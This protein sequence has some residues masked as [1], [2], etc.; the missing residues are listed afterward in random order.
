[1]AT[2]STTIEDQSEIQYQIRS[3]ESRRIQDTEVK[4][5]VLQ[6]I[7]RQVHRAALEQPSE[8]AGGFMSFSMGSLP[9]AKP[10]DL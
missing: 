8:F 10:R 3:D 6:E 4:D 2:E 1:M 5:R 9:P 7:H